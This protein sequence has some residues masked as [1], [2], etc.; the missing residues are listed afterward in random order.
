MADLSDVVN[1]LGVLAQTA[2]Y[3]N[4]T[5]SAS[6]SGNGIL[7]AAGWPLPTQLDALISAGNAM[8]SIYPMPGMDANTTR[9]LMEEPQALNTPAAS[10]TMSVSNNTVT[11]GGTI[12]AGE[13]AFISVN[14]TP[15][16]HG[17][18]STDTTATI[19]S[20]L[21]SQIPNATASGSVVTVGGT[22]FNLV[23]SVSAIASLQAEIARQRRVFMLTAWCPNPTA[24]DTIIKSLDLYLKTLPG[25]RFL[26]Q[27]NTYAVLIYR[28]TLETDELQKTQIYRRDLR[29]EVEY[30]TTQ[31]STSNTITN[32]QTGISIDG[33]P[34]VQFNVP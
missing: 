33:A 12:N 8:L 18:V 11:V 13:A 1:Q 9:F 26:L 3:P 17:I 10:L 19:A 6:V 23:A 14:N 16:S 29:Y 20:A 24:R 28:G 21:A 5:G 15:Y 34:S 27:D 32:V 22:V 7:I 25:R 31:T 2:L 4:G 30:A